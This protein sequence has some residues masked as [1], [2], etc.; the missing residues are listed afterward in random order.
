MQPKIIDKKESVNN[1]NLD[2]AMASAH[3][4]NAS[5]NNSQKISLII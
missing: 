5:L 4:K 3:T 1:F 2:F